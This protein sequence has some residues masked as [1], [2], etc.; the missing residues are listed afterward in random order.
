MYQQYEEDKKS[1]KEKIKNK[2]TQMLIMYI[3]ALLA[4]NKHNSTLSIF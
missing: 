3:P 2:T 4:K 1:S